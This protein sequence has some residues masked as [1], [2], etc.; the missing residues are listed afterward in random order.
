M[1]GLE[2]VLVGLVFESSMETVK[3]LHE[4][5]ETYQEKGETSVPITELKNCISAGIDEATKKDSLTS[6][7]MKK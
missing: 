1:D 2:Q 3:R 5:I 4:V 7:L 6:L